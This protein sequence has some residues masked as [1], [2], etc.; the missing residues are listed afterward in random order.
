V[1]RSYLSSRAGNV[2]TYLIAAYRAFRL[3]D[4]GA[5]PTAVLLKFADP[6]VRK[7]MIADLLRTYYP[8]IIPLGQTNSKPAQLAEAFAQAFES[9]TGESRVK[10][11]RFFLAAPAYSDIKLSP[12]WKPPKAPRGSSAPRRAHKPNGTA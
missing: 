5:H 6:E 9:V 11:I 3:I 10:A 2:Q 8:T 4:E 7:G 1:D 12:L